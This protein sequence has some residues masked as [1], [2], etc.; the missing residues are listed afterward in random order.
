MPKPPASNGTAEIQAQ[1][2]TKVPEFGTDPDFKGTYSGG[3]KP[4][5]LK[6]K[7]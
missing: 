6:L 1:G 2:Q 3:N 7:A 5:D 4:T